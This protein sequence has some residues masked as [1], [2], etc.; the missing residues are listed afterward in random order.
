MI[1]RCH[2]RCT[3]SR[4]SIPNNTMSNQS[5]ASQ[6]C[7]STSQENLLRTQESSPSYKFES[8]TSFPHNL[9]SNFIP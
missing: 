1:A 7:G 2:F 8:T 6:P 9:P 5:Q 3:R 4:N